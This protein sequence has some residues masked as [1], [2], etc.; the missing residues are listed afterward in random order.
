MKYFTV[1]KYAMNYV[2]SFFPYWQLGQNCTR[3]IYFGLDT[4]KYFLNEEASY[5][6]TNSV[7]LTRVDDVFSCVKTTTTINYSLT[8][9]RKNQQRMKKIDEILREYF[10]GSTEAEMGEIDAASR[11]VIISIQ[12]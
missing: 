8:H 1:H 6:S 9:R 10:E 12:K 2:A 3:I 5:C 7:S 11:N 4:R